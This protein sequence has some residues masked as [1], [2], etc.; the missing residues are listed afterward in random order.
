MVEKFIRSDHWSKRG[1]NRPVYASITNEINWQIAQL[2]K[3]GL[4]P[5]LVRLGLHASVIYAWEHWT[6]EA[7]IEDAPTH[8]DGYRCR[9]P[10]RYRD[11]KVSGVFVEGEAHQQS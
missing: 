4:Q 5:T 8:H 6:K 7:R 9:V 2:R 11:P 3:R 10:I 1:F